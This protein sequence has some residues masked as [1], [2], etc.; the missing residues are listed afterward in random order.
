MTSMF[1]GATAFNQ[2]SSAWDTS[3][4]TNMTNMF[5]GATAFNQNLS[6]WNVTS[7]TTKPPTTF[8]TSA[9]AWTL[10]KPIWT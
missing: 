4:V 10:P 1:Y 8:N 7:V 5:Y 6:G 3:K 2:N 9:T